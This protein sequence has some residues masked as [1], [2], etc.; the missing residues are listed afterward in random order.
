MN[1]AQVSRWWSH[2]VTPKSLANRRLRELKRAGLVSLSR[3]LAMKP[4]RIEE[5]LA[6]WQP[7]APLPDFGA[8]S[9]ESKKRWSR[10]AEVMTLVTATK[11]AANRFGGSGGSRPRDVEVSHDLGVAETYLFFREHD[12]RAMSWV[13]EASLKRRG[14]GKNKEPLPDALVSD[15]SLSIVIEFVGRY[16]TKRLK[17]HHDRMVVREL[18]YELW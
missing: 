13:S 5:R 18:A 10:R 3:I 12:P 6:R 1:A 2:S 4:P 11:A 15:G 7:G 14:A 8:I 9:W 17:E 16:S